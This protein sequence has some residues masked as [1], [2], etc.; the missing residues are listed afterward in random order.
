MTA[1]AA[2]KLPEIPTLVARRFGLPDLQDCTP[3]LVPR[4]SRSW[5]HLQDRTIFGWFHG[6]IGSSEFFFV[7][8]DHAVTLAQQV[9]E[10]LS[11]LPVVREHFTL[12]MKPEFVDE[13]AFLYTETKQWAFRLG[14]SEVLLQDYYDEK[15]H[16]DLAVKRLTDVPRDLVKAAF[17]RVFIRE[18]LFARIGPQPK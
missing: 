7:R 10:K 9:H 2:L 3:W 5:P 4:L 15:E 14:A 17:G 18:V 11:P 16:P 1:A 8:T 13:A 6:I 12:A